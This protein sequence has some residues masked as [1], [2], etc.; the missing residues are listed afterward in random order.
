MTRSPSVNRGLQLRQRGRC[1]RQPVQFTFWIA[2]LRQRR[3]TKGNEACLRQQ[4]QCWTV[5]L[6]WA[7]RQAL[8]LF[9]NGDLR[10]VAQLLVAS[11]H[12]IVR[13][14]LALNLDLVVVDVVRTY[15]QD[16]MGLLTIPAG[17]PSFLR[18]RLEV[19]RWSCVKHPSN[20]GLI[21][22][23]AKSACARQHVQ[24]P[25]APLLVAFLF[26]LGG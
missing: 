14:K 1:G 24:P 4:I 19:G 2:L 13:W 6:G 11:P 7:R 5:C 9:P 12:H 18:V 8:G 16:T 10:F 26:G 3:F 17:T 15:V 22:A 21:D 25:F 20:I 23:H